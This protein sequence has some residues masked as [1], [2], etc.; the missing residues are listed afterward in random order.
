[1]DEARKTNYL[2]VFIHDLSNGRFI[3]RSPQI[4][5]ISEAI[6]R[7]MERV[8]LKNEDPKASLDQACTEIGRA[9]AER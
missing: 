4:I 8:V 5:E 7:A 1:M 2:D 9:L 3:Q 6:H